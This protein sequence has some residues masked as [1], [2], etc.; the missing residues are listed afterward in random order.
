MAKVLVTGA[1][2]MLG[3]DI[4]P[5]LEQ[6]GYEVFKTDIDNMDITNI[7]SVESVISVQ[8]PDIVI[9]CVLNRIYQFLAIESQ[10]SETL[11][12]RIIVFVFLE[13][14]NAYPVPVIICIFNLDPLKQ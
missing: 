9:H 5:I 11:F 12:P 13:K 8:N 2:G 4:C 6:N 1:N 3:Q 14:T 10:I 7:D